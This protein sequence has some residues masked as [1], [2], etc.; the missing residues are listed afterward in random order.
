MSQNVED[1]SWKRVSV[2]CLR[3]TLVTL[4]DFH[5]SKEGA[6]LTSVNETH[7]TSAELHSKEP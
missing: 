6:F 1:A 2:S 7:T 4:A 3:Q 5:R